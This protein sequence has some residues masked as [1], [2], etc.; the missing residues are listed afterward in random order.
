MIFVEFN[1]MASKNLVETCFKE[2]YKIKKF[3][4]LVEFEKCRIMNAILDFFA[5]KDV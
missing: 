5:I 4:E 3:N 2:N 1:L